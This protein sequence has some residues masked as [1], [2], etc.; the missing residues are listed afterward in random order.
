ML[1]LVCCANAGATE[2]SSSR[3]AAPIANPLIQSSQQRQMVTFVT[4]KTNAAPMWPMSTVGRLN[5]LA[6]LSGSVN[7]PL[8]RSRLLE[9][10]EQALDLGPLRGVRGN[11][12]QQ[13][14]GRGARVGLASKPRVD[15]G[16]IET[17]FVKV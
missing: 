7:G 10:G 1:P 6:S 12:A 11:P 9:R 2:P 5:S 16:Q 15:E 8:A 17:R 13:L 3:S 4:T 14:L